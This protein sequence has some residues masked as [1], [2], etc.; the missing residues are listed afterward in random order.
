MSTDELLGRRDHGGQPAFHVGRSAAIEHAIA[1]FRHERVA[2]PL[3]EWARRHDVGMSGKAEERGRRRAPGPEISDL[4]EA[5]R[6]D[7]KADPGEPLRKHGLAPLISG[8]QGTARDQ[9]FSEFKGLRHEL[10]V[11][12]P[13]LQRGKRRWRHA[14]VK[15]RGKTMYATGMW[16]Y[17]SARVSARAVMRASY[18]RHLMR[19]KPD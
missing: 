5:Q 3:I 4:S 15:S 6:L 2:V 18:F 12:R 16:L 14:T 8:G 19:I 1:D 13:H 9:I 10:G 7:A 17:C 11:I